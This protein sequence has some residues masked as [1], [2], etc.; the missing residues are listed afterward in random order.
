[1]IVRTLQARCRQ[2]AVHARAI[3]VCVAVTLLTS[4]LLPAAETGPTWATEA[5]QRVIWQDP[6][7]NPLPFQSDE[8]IIEFLRSASIESEED[9]PTGVTKPRKAILEKDGVRMRAA[10]RDFEETFTGQRFERVFY[11]RLRDSFTFDVPAY[12]LS[13]LMGLDNVPPVTF[14]RLGSRRVTLQ[15]WLEG[16]MMERD[17]VANSL[18]PP[19]AQRHR[20]QVQN[21]KVFDSIVGNID[22]HTGNYMAD[23]DGDFWLIDH[24]RSFVRNA[25]DMPYLEEIVA[26]ERRLFERIKTLAREEILS[27]TSPTLTASEVDW[28]L[29]RRDKVVA[30]I[31]NLIETRGGEG[32]VLFDVPVSSR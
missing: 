6:A 24:S 23:D 21:M 26:C 10:L 31:E 3:S 4:P 29:R 13:R 28:I 30:H 18:A 15:I 14:R 19:S 12:E 25:D 7:G 20:Q 11:A 8:E 27:V 9:I 16:G 2:R 22:R 5:S 1:M 17:R 32:A